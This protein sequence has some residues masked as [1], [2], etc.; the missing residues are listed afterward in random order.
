LLDNRGI[1]RFWTAISVRA[2]RRAA[3][4]TNGRIY[5]VCRWNSQRLA[6]LGALDG[7]SRA[8]LINHDRR[9]AT[10]AIESNVHRS[11]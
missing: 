5:W 8:R 4:K 3:L 2:L 11:L 9:A 10:G 6:A 7:H 1:E